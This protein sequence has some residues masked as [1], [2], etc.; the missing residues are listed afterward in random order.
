MNICETPT[1]RFNKSNFSIRI[2]DDNDDD[3]ES[4]KSAKRRGVFTGFF[5]N[6]FFMGP[7]SFDMNFIDTTATTPNVNESSQAGKNR[8]QEQE[9][10][11]EQEQQQQR[12]QSKYPFETA[13]NVSEESTYSICSTSDDDDDESSAFI[14]VRNDYDHHGISTGKSSTTTAGGHQYPEDTNYI[15]TFRSRTNIIVH[16]LLEL[17]M[18]KTHSKFIMFAIFFQFVHNCFT[19]IAYY[20]QTKLSA[21]QRVPLTDIGFALLPKLTGEWWMVSEYIFTVIVAFPAALT[22][23]ILFIRWKLPHGKPL[24]AVNILRRI[25]MT[26]V[27]CQSL[28]IISFLVTTLPGASRQCLY[29]VP[30][31]LTSQ[32]MV[33]NVADPGGNPRY[34]IHIFT[35]I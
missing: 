10:E 13:T 29:H 35:L 18:L 24:Y 30:D 32:E 23:S 27:C 25:L 20:Y 17:S 5:S 14:E 1:S 6:L 33:H 4:K 2:Y 34:D 3:D 21:A 26:L 19:N 22:F 7:H 9:Q 28:R 31:N 12:L 16:F 15:Y 8:Q 11:Q